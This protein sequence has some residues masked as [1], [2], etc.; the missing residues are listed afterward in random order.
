MLLTCLLPALLV[1]AAGYVQFRKY[2]EAMVL[3]QQER[4]LLSHRDFIEAFLRNRTAELMA[5]AQGYTLPQL[6]RGE[7]QRVFH[8]MQQGSGIYTDI[9]IIDDKGDHILYLGP[10]NLQGR[11]YRET[12]WF[13]VLL[14]QD[15]YV[16]DLF[17]GYRAV[18]HFIVAVKHE[19]GGRFY[20]L[21]ASLS[22]DTFSE[23]V[24]RVRVGRT[25]EAFLLDR[26]GRFQTKTLFGGGLLQKAP[27]PPLEPHPGIRSAEVQERGRKVLYS[28]VWMA[29]DRWLLVF[30]QEKAEAYGPLTRAFWTW[31]AVTVAGLFGV[32]T[33]ALLIS[34][35]LV[36]YV[37]RADE[38]K[39]AL[40]R[41]LLA[42][43]RLAALGEMAAGVAHE[44]NN[45]LG[46]IETLKTWIL[47]LVTPQGVRS[48]DLP[49]VLDSARKIGDQVERCRRITHDLLKF[50]RK[51]EGEQASLDLNALLREM[52]EMVQHRARAENVS[53]RLDL[54]PLPTLVASPSK[55]QQIVLNILNNAVDAL[56]GRGGTVTL[57]SRAKRDRVVV[58]FSDNGPGIPPENLHRIFEPF[59]TTKPVGRGT[60][61]GL[62]VCYGLA[63]QMGGT[64]E[65]ESRPGEGATF[66][67]TLPLRPP[68]GAEG[69]AE[70]SR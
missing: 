67:L 65:A 38:E 58:A 20:I 25:G 40:H 22:T 12:E 64:L 56:E 31:V 53:F 34:R 9:G 63:Q 42:S 3:D 5:V 57:T 54:A 18:P 4:L 10:Y 59:F 62:A 52:V 43:S 23:M 49:E 61:L 17:M 36:R 16:S 39:E 51:V 45:P 47:D 44:I 7:L 6:M 21:R 60:G 15:V 70:G 24:E 37:R 29:G 48:E 35:N 41:Q 66:I 32:T 13:Q 19:E 8:V 33:A 11:N 50:S 14:R 2:A 28:D 46:I 55:L 26:Q 1:G 69:S 30:R 68:G 27:Y